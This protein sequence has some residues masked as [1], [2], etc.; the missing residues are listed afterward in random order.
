MCNVSKCFDNNILPL[1]WSA[2][3]NRIGSKQSKGFFALGDY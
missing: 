3:P 1:K 2:E